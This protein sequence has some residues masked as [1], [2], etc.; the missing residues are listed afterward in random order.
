MPK[1][2]ATISRKTAETT[3]E[4]SLD[5]DGSGKV[6]A[7]TG[8]GFFDHMLTLLGRHALID[9]SVNAEGDTGV[10][11]HHTVED[12]GICLG[13]ALAQALGDKKGIVRY[14]HMLLPMDEA[15]AQVALDLSG[16]AHLE[17]HGAIPGEKCGEF[18]TCLG[19]EFMRAFTQN[20]GINMHVD[21]LRAEDPHHA[22]EAIFKGVGR[23]LRTA[24]ATDPREKGVPSSK[25]VL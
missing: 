15:L 12:V 22:L 1:R 10:D 17:W 18:D 25:G 8:V 16:R 21:L 14:G 9:F 4:L 20:G 6:N 5:L 11:A 2:T 24:V 23:A 19:R 3:I 13:L 7:A